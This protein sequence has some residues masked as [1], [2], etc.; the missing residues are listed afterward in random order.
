M[1]MRL[2]VRASIEYACVRITYA[3]VK[4]HLCA[5]LPTANMCPSARK[6][7]AYKILKPALRTPGTQGKDTYKMYIFQHTFPRIFLQLDTHLTRILALGP[8]A[9]VAPGDNISKRFLA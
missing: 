2:W 1:Y 5:C 9:Y 7:G 4:L 3:Y 8:G 6:T